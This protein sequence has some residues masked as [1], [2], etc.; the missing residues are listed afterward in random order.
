MVADQNSG[1][2]LID[3]YIELNMVF[4]RVIKRHTKA[5]DNILK[6]DKQNFSL[7][8]K[9]EIIGLDRNCD[10]KW[11]FTQVHGLFRLWTHCSIF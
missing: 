5:S 2:W 4:L 1:I 11:A 8:S 9:A 7:T 3:D 10:E 6:L